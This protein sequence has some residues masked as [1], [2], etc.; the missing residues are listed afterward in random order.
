VQRGNFGTARVPLQTIQPAGKNDHRE[1]SLP[2]FLFKY[3]RRRKCA[4]TKICMFF[5][6]NGSDLFTTVWQSTGRPALR[7]WTRN[8]L[9]CGTIERL[10]GVLVITGANM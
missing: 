5:P 6:I 3:T 10:L 7:F 1:L 2:R 9:L 8:P 4:Y